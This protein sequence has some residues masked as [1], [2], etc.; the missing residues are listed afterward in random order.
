MNLFHW[1]L[2]ETLVMFELNAYIHNFERHTLKGS[3]VNRSR[4]EIISIG[5]TI[6]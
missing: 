2:F 6:R 5:L 1:V 4:V 3:S